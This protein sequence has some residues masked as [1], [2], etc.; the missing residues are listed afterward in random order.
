[1]IFS[2]DSEFLEALESPE[3]FDLRL[4]QLQKQRKVYLALHIFGFL[5]FILSCFV[6]LYV[7]Q[8][9]PALF[10]AMLMLLMALHQL[11]AVVAAQNEIRMLLAFK[12]LREFS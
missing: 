1:M 3:A 7:K 11:A 2:K 4:A 12:K 6:G 9:G 10:G 5:A 8:T